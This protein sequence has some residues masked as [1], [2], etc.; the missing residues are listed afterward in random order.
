MGGR[1]PE[2]LAPLTWENTQPPSST[3]ALDGSL[4]CL[5]PAYGPPAYARNGPTIAST[6]ARVSGSSNAAVPFT[7]PRK[8][9]GAAPTSMPS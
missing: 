2:G 1:A 3:G 9:P 4:R 7:R 6:W 8:G 5:R